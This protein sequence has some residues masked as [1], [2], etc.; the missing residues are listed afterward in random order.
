MGG[1]CAN[2]VM[3]S[4]FQ[5]KPFWLATQR[6]PQNDWTAT[7]NRVNYDVF[8]QAPLLTKKIYLSAVRPTPFK[9]EITWSLFTMLPV[10]LKNRNYKK[11]RFRK[12]QVGRLSST[13]GKNNSLPGRVGWQR[14]YGCI[15]CRRD[16]TEDTHTHLMKK[17]NSQGLC[18]FTKCFTWWLF[19]QVR[20]KQN[21]EKVKISRD[22]LDKNFPRERRARNRTLSLK[23][24]N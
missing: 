12:H 3:V 14:E 24:S 1:A 20:Q 15:S 9:L 22:C 4:K 5:W 10:M 17:E 21:K 11:V 23:Y 18:V 7:Q 16:L 19:S 6:D 2:Y 13:S 8:A